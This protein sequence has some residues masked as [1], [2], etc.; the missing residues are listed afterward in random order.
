MQGLFQLKDAQTHC[1]H[2]RNGGK[3]Q[4]VG[5]CRLGNSVRFR[6]RVG[7]LYWLKAWELR[8]VEG[9]VQGRSGVSSRILQNVEQSSKMGVKRDK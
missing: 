1:L 7:H 3:E 8:R 2:L 4:W 6:L 5:A 9:K